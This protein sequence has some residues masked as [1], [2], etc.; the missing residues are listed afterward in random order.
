MRNWNK[1]KDLLKNNRNKERTA[2]CL[3]NDWLSTLLLSSTFNTLNTTPKKMVQQLGHHE[4]PS[5]KSRP[6]HYPTV[7][8]CVYFVQYCQL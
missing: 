1:L 5:S 2:M 7:S 8:C 6:S 4:G 3:D